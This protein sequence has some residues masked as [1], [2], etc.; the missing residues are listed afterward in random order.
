[1]NTVA[2][3]RKKENDTDLD[4]VENDKD[5]CPNSPFGEEVDENGCTLASRKLILI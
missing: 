3:R 5:R 4:G 2:Q 1:M